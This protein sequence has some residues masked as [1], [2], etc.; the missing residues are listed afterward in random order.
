MSVK[1]GYI[2]IESIAALS[3]FSKWDSAAE[4][5]WDDGV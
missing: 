2:C 1:H 4:Q 5:M 3:V